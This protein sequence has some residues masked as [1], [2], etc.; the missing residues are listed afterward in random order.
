MI[1]YLPTLPA[2][3]FSIYLTDPLSK[4]NRQPPRGRGDNRNLKRNMLVKAKVC[5][6]QDVITKVACFQ[7]KLL[8][9]A[10]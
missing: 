6:A 4:Q 10:R 3:T 5:S 9:N 2:E 7:D 8:S 1:S